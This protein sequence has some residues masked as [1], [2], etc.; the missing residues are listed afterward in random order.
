MI[1]YRAIA[2][3]ERNNFSLRNRYG[4]APER[5]PGKNSTKPNGP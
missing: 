5:L 3:P 2:R 4:L 1:F